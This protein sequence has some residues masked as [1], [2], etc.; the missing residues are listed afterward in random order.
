MARSDTARELAARHGS[1]GSWVVHKSSQLLAF[2]KPAGLAVQTAREGQPSLQRL[3]SAYAKRDLY[4][5]HRIDQPVSGLVLFGRHKGKAAALQQQF[6][7]GT[8]EREYLAVVE[9]APETEPGELRHLLGHDAR[10]NKAYVAGEGD[11][12]AREALLS[13]EQIGATERYPVLRLR[14]RT[15]RPHQIRAQLAA[16]GAPIHGDVKYGARRAKP[17]RSIQLHAHALT[18]DHPVSGE[19]VHLRAPLP[20]GDPLWAA[21]AELA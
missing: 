17:D 6:A 2:A 8:V 10:S 5:L 14:L 15:G 3:A 11:A 1:I 12:R 19:R 18:L 7:K 13:W 4:L 21:V 16:A 9:S 20:T